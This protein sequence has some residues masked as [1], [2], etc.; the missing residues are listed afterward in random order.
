MEQGS[1][2]HA[3]LFWTAC[4]LRRLTWPVPGTPLSPAPPPL[5]STRP[6]A[7]QAVRAPLKRFITSSQSK[8]GL[9]TQLV[10]SDACSGDALLAWLWIPAG[11]SVSR[12]D[13]SSTLSTRKP[14]LVIFPT[15]CYLPQRN[16][17]LDA[18]VWTAQR[19][20]SSALST[21]SKA[22][23][24]ALVHGCAVPSVYRTAGPFGARRTFPRARA[25]YLECFGSHLGM[26]CARPVCPCACPLGAQR[27]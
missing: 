5:S 14:S 27:T 6:A 12:V 8:W 25:G 15:A 10:W 3:A 21:F 22:G 7:M 2:Q 4:R 18:K 1:C 24:G 20:V 26:R 19:T 9:R 17:C 13:L 16:A 23:A 11:S